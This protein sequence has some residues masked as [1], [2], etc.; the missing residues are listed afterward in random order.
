MDIAVLYI[1]TGDYSVFWNNFYKSSELY[2]LPNHKKHYFVFTDDDNIETTHNITKIF[3]KC[4]GFPFDS[5]YRFK[6]FL[7]IK[8]ELLKYDFIYFFNSNMIFLTLINDEILPKQNILENGLLAVLHP[9]H[10]QKHFIWYPYERNT[11]S[12]AYIPYNRIKKYFYFMGGVN[13]GV[14]S[15]YL[16]LIETCAINIDKDS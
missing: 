11:S 5:L 6:M 9:G 12:L 10:F 3:K 8:S 16:K 14:S 1:G 15:Q 4:E 7:T 13:G 2:F